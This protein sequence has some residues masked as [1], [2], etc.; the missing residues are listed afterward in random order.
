MSVRTWAGGIALAALALLGLTIAGGG[1]A[2]VPAAGLGGDPGWLEGAYGGGLGLGGGA[3]IWLERAALVAYAVV[4]ACAGALGRRLLWTAIVVLAIAFAAAPPLLSQDVFSYLAYT[5]LEGLY[6]LNP[7]EHVPNDV[8]GDPVFLED[9]RDLPSVY[10][11]LFTVLTLPLAQLGIGTAVYALKAVAAASVLAIAWVAARLATARG[12]DPRAAAALVALNPLVLTHVIGGAHNDAP[13][14]ALMTAGIA[15]IALG[16]ERAGGLALVAAAGVKSAALL[17]APFALLGAGARR[18]GGAAALGMAAGA[19]LVL[20]VGLGWF[21]SSALEAI[22]VA[23]RNQDLNSS[24]SLPVTLAEA[25]GLE[26]ETVKA[27]CLGLLAVAI[28]GLL[29]Y[30]VRGGDWIRALGW[31]F[32]AVLLASSYVTPWYVIW[33][34]PPAAVSRDRSLIAATVLL[35]AFLLREQVPGLGG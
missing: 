2:A 35:S 23:G 31:A 32:L 16:L 6:G 15:G 4:V 17:A 22:E 26:L 34:L 20:A 9:N 27:V 24:A 13:M 5:R 14:A 3:Y 7:Y 10:G 19:A 30:A 29:A 25:L 18:R 12:A 11:P 8:P 33:L 21:G 28:A 1:S